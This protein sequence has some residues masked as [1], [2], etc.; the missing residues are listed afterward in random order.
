[1]PDDKADTKHTGNKPV[2]DLLGRFEQA[3]VGLVSGSGERGATR[4]ARL[5]LWLTAALMF[6]FLVWAAV[7]QLDVV[8]TASGEVIPSTKVK[9]VQHLEGGIIREIKVREGDVVNAGQPLMILEET[10]QG[11]SVEELEVRIVSLTAE[12]AMHIALAE[13]KDKLVFPEGFQKQHPDLTA[14]TMDLFKTKL[15]RIRGEIAA[16]KENVIQRQEDINEIE[17]RLRNN[18][19]SLKIIREQVSLSAELLKDNLTTEFQHLGYLR[20]Q[21][22]YLN[23]I[24]QDKAALPRAKSSLA[25]ARQNLDSSETEFREN[26]KQDLRKARREFEEFTQR[27]RKF[28]DSLQRTIIRSPVEGVIKKLH[29]VTI[30]GVVQAGETIVDIV[31][32]SDR[33][34]VEAHLPIG[35]IGYVQSGQRAVVKLASSDAARF[36]KLEGTVVQVSPDTFTTPEGA[37]YYSVRIETKGDSFAHGDFEYN[38]IPGMLVMVYIH[39]GNRTVLEYLLDPFI[40]SVD[41]ALHER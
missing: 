15:R 22:S 30:G 11:A 18:R 16:L 7:G 1:M 2:Q 39:T 6:L 24:E 28:A 37:T 34:V 10:F 21:S 20:E 41:E 9:S 8:S 36:G 4:T 14:Q 40:G 31:P 12:V 33:L 38:L 27:M 17:A 3:I 5:F 23:K 25:E 13:G 26:A 32:S 35:D 19:N 29:Y